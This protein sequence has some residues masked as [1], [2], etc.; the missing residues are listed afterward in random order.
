MKTKRYVKAWLKTF[1]EISPDHL[2][3]SVA[4]IQ[5]LASEGAVNLNDLEDQIQIKM[6]RLK[7]FAKKRP[8]T[9]FNEEHQ[10]VGHGPVGLNATD[11][12]LV[13]GE[14]TLYAPSPWDALI[15]VFYLMQPVV[16][17]S[18]C[19]LTD[20]E[21]EVKVMP[22]GI[23]TECE[24]IYISFLHPD[25]LVADKLDDISNWCVA[26]YKDDTADQYLEKYP[27][28]IAIPLSQAYQF[29]RDVFEYWASEPE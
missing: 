29:A 8:Q 27:N 10:I 20:R 24:G 18:K 23:E 26:L 3:F 5:K 14:K 1:G 4:L 7:N 19:A 28:R 16:W 6:R 12:I 11:Q 2:T 25:E 13:L 15:S 17:K 22:E 9:Q 21:I